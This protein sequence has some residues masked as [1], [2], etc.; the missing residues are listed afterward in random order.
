M[1]VVMEFDIDIILSDLGYNNYSSH[2]KA[3]IK[4]LNG[5]APINKA[6]ERQLVFC[7]SEG[8]EAILSVSR[9]KAGV[10]LCKNSIEGIV[11]SRF[12]R[13]QRLI[14]GDH[15][16]LAAIRIIKSLFQKE[17]LVGLSDRAVVSKNAKIGKDCYIGDFS[18]I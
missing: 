7:S 10:I 13:L 12:D 9:S 4:I 15:P 17:P 8:E 18:V 11:F 2:G 5:I 6:T 1:T 16:R 14:F 3:S